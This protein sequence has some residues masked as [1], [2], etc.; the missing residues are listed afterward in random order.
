MKH[1]DLFEKFL[2]ETVNLNKTRVETAASGIDTITSFLKSGDL[3]KNLFVTTSPQGSY[4]QKTIIKPPAED[5]EFDVDLLFEMKIVE[6]WEP[7]DYHKRVADQ[8]RTSDRYKD[9][10]DTKGKCRCV[11]ID[12]ESD[13]HIDVVPAVRT[14]N[15]LQIINKNMNAFEPTDGD[16]Y[17]NWFEAKSVLAQGFLVEIVRLV[18]YIRDTRQRFNVKSILLTT[19]LGNLVFETD[20]L[21]DY[22]DLPTSLKILVNRLD[23]YLQANTVMPVVT[24]PMLPTESFNRHWDQEKYDLFKKQVQ[25]LNKE[26]NDAYDEQDET[27]S[28]EEWQ[29]IFGD[30]FSSLKDEMEDKAGESVALGNT[31]HAQAPPWPLNLL[32]KVKINAYVFI[33]PEINGNSSEA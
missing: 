16:G 33:K 20:A 26:V 3:T 13:F 6:G 25:T 2:K 19:L 18:K 17:A 22:A 30:D 11:T 21:K 14:Q 27:E 4:R 10:V 29:L 7:K 12:Y 5:I 9:K 1:I 8:F 15:G 28:V 31:G 23:A 32:Y 24:N